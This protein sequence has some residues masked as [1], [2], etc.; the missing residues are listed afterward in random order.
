[1]GLAVEQDGEVVIRLERDARQL[2]L[3]PRFPGAQR[4]Q[5]NVEG[6]RVQLY[7]FVDDRNVDCLAGQLGD[8]GGCMTIIPEGG[9]AVEGEVEDADPDMTLVEEVLSR[10]RFV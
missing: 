2:I 8:G 1:M 7:I 3:A 9:N 4:H 6:E 5:Q 10:N